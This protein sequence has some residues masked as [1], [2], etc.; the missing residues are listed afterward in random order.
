MT[1]QPLILILVLAAAAFVATAVTNK[2]LEKRR[3]AQPSAMTAE[4]V[5]ISLESALVKEGN[6]A[7]LDIAVIPQY[8]DL[9]ISTFALELTISRRS[10]QRV[11]LSGKMTVDQSLIASSW[12]FPILSATEEHNGVVVKLSGVHVETTPFE[13]TGRQTI[14]RIPVEASLTASDLAVTVN[15]EHTKFLQKDTTPIPVDD[16]VVVK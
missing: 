8:D 16:T 12:A 6:G 11:G 10:G 14:A 4:Q 7:V 3:A 5:G 15:M 13:L 9:A 2:I 1:K